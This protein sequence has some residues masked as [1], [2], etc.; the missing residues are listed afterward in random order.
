MFLNVLHKLAKS[1][2]IVVAVVSCLFVFFAR[3]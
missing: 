3:N 2:A 1:F